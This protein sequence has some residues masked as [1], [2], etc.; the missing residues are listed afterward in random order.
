MMDDKTRQKLVNASFDSLDNGDE[1]G[2]D[3]NYDDDADSADPTVSRTRV[4]RKKAKRTGLSS[5]SI[6]V[7]TGVAT[8]EVA[9]ILNPLNSVAFQENDLGTGCTPFTPADRDAVNLNSKAY[10][11]SAGSLILQA[12]AGTL[13]TISCTSNISYRQLVATMMGDNYKVFCPFV[14]MTFTSTPQLDQA[15]QIGYRNM[16]GKYGVNPVTPSDYFTPDQFQSKT[17]DIPLNVYITGESRIWYTILSG[18]T[19]TFNF[20]VK[21]VPK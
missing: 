6:K 8:D 15:L 17:V 13:I 1:D 12:A 2:Y 9:E 3:D 14:R 20:F 7:V 19:N 11:N 4:A 18:E 16:F 21:K 5:F 10:Y